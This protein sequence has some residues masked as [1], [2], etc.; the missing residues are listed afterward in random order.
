[1][2]MLDMTQQL[3]IF[4]AIKIN[5]NINF[6]YS[7]YS[8]LKISISSKYIRSRTK[9][10]TDYIFG[11]IGFSFFAKQWQ[12]GLIQERYRCNQVN[13]CF[14]QGL[15]SLSVYVFVVLWIYKIIFPSPSYMNLYNEKLKTKIG[16]QQVK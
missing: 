13:Y 4:A 14:I 12:E 7:G 3:C 10:Q 11:I 15:N 6:F 16:L 8:N 9:L 5:V 1:M 2:F